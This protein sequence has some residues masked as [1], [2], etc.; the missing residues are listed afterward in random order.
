MFKLA[1]PRYVIKKYAG[2]KYPK[3]DKKLITAEDIIEKFIT[4]KLLDKKTN[5]TTIGSC[6]AQRLRD[7]LIEKNFNYKD[8]KWD[9][10]YS[11]RNIK[12]IMQMAFE[13]EKL[14]I[15]EPI[16]NFNGDCG[17]PYIKSVEG[18][19]MKIPCNPK[20]AKEKIKS[21][22]KHFNKIL[23]ECKVL[24]ITLGQTEVWSHK[25]APETAFYAAP[26]VGIKDGEKN[27]ISHDLTIDEIKHE[28]KEIMRIMKKN[29]PNVKIVFSIS[30]I[31]LV[32][33]ISDD[34]SA[35]IAANHAKTKLHSCTLE[36]MKEYENVYYMPS[37]EL[38]N[39]HPYSAFR[40]D[41]RHVPQN[42][43]N[44]IMKMF[45]KL[46]VNE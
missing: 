19:P 31:P 45:S 22:Y 33:S 40:D 18:R 7:Y 26:F 23:K 6:F 46:Y 14:K 27:H 20:E 4:P 15:V 16:W 44:K 39:A 24:I 8:G 12:Q 25:D 2:K 30:P 10:V 13:P 34:Y 36:L 38:V 28:F 21:K 5:I 9:R 41:G 35:Y 29:N 32:A 42:F 11:I 43:A 3:K 37:F 17:D 1:R